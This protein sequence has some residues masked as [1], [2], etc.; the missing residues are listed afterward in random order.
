VIAGQNALQSSTFGGGAGSLVFDSAVGG[1]FTLGGLSGSSALNLVD[2]ASGAVA[3]SVG[4]NNSSTTYSGALGGAGSLT[5][6]GYGVLTLSGASGYSGATLVSQGALNVQNASALGS[7]AAGTT[8]AADATLQLQGGVTVTGEALA[9]TGSGVGGNGALR[10]ISGDNAWTG[11][12]TITGGTATGANRIHVD[13]GLLT[14]SGDINLAATS[15]TQLHVGTSDTGNLTISGNISG[16]TE[17]SVG[18]LKSTVNTGG[19][20]HGVLTLSGVNTYLG[21]TYIGYGTLA[22][23]GGSALP[24]GTTVNFYNTSATTAPAVLELLSHETI[25]A[26]ASGDTTNGKVKLNGFT[27]SV[28]AADSSTTFAGVIQG[29]GGLTKIGSASL[30]LTNLQEYTGTTTVSAGLL[31]VTGALSNNAADH[32][33]IQSAGTAFGSN[34]AR[35]ARTWFEGLD[36]SATDVGSSITG[37]D[38][39]TAASMLAGTA[40]SDLTVTMAWRQGTEDEKTKQGGGLIS[41]VLKL[42]GTGSEIFTLQM[43]YSEAALASIWGEQ[44]PE[45]SVYLAWYSDAESKWLNAVAGNTGETGALAVAGYQ[46]TWADFVATLGSGWTLADVLGSYGVDAEGNQ[47]WAVVDHN[48]QFAVV[49]EPGTIALLAAGLLGLIAY[50]W[51]RRK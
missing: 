19:S 6:I 18:L 25:G 44:I 46:G 49:P 28:G 27:L 3:L 9:L 50:A 37:G 24:D 42:D 16:S 13:D 4:K 31:N 21:A 7:T 10:N 43:S 51:R 5:K 39:G 11:D 45:S 12:L 47:A 8:V 30:T 38:Y 22:V 23:S 20:T 40:A 36:L 32:V 2:S 17:G 1:A 35:I 41:D 33:L 34:D 26:L 29:A 48:S 14:I 15:G